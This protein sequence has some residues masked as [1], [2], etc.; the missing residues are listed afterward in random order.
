MKQCLTT[1]CY[2]SRSVSY[3]VIIKEVGGNKPRDTQLDNG[4]RM[5]DFGTISLTWNQSIK[6]L[7]SQVPWNPAEEETERL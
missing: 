3:L 1:C 6:S 4:Q 2:N 7:P 5:R